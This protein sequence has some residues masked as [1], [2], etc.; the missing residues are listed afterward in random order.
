M[1]KETDCGKGCFSIQQSQENE[2]NRII[3]GEESNI[4]SGI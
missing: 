3:S 1:I 4:G 2:Y